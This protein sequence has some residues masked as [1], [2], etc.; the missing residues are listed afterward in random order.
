MHFHY[1]LFQTHPRPETLNP[2]AINFTILVEA[3]MIYTIM[4]QV[5]FLDVHE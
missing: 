2:R 1:D 3:S 4:N 5:C